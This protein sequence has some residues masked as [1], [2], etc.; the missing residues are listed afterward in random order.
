MITL[1]QLN[2]MILLCTNVDEEELTEE[3]KNQVML[4]SQWLWQQDQFDKLYFSSQI[5]LFSVI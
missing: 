4:A 5:K 2:E 1:T 3:Q